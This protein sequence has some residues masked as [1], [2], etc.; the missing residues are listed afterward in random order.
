MTND[1]AKLQAVQ[2]SVPAQRRA[3]GRVSK[4]Y[5]SMRRTTEADVERTLA[6]FKE[7]LEAAAR[8]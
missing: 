7:A 5:V 8:L 1:S 3:E 6:V 4:I 2:R